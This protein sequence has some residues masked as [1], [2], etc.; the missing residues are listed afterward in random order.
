M[1]TPVAFYAAQLLSTNGN[2]AVVVGTGNKG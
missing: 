2:P 1:R